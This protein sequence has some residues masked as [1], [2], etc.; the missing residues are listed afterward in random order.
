M[1]WFM[2]FLIPLLI[3]KSAEDEAIDELLE[4]V[5]LSTYGLERKM[6]NE[7]LDLEEEEAVLDPQN[8]GPRGAHGG[9]EEL[10]IL[11]EIA[12]S[13]NGRWFSG[14][15][16]TP[17]EHKIKLIDF[18]TKVINHP[19]IQEK[20]LN[21][22]DVYNRK[23]AFEKIIEDVWVQKRKQDLEW[24]KLYAKDDS[25]KQAFF[26]TMKRMVDGGNLRDRL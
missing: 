16:E 19:D 9:E 18:K 4:S 7:S 21:N 24:Y 5:D 1:Y 20:F 22:K 15:N 3:V 26:D 17:E 14:L 8:S 12:H 11:D 6:L 2:K 23:I 13:F 25:F 10:D